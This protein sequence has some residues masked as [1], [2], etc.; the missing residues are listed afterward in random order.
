MGI[1][2]TLAL[3]VASAALGLTLIGGGTFAYFSSTSQATGT[4][5]AG[6]LELNANPTTIINVSNIKPG[7]KAVRN[8]KLENNGTLD[9]SRVLLGT[10]YTVTNKAG[11]PANTDD[12]GKHIRVNFLTNSD[13]GDRV[14][15]STNLFDLQKLT[16]DAVENKVFIPWLEEHGGLKAGT[17]DKL[18]VEFEFVDNNQDQN[19]FQGDSLTLTW[20]FEAKQGAGVEK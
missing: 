4:F 6:T 15:Y 13:K 19:Q 10:S 1:K 11:A 16:P 3:G 5:A 14:I 17:S 9:I 2:K 20:K 7:D 12:F 8:F 18:T